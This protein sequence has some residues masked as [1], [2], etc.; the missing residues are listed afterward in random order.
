[1]YKI[2]CALFLTTFPIFADADNIDLIRYFDI[3]KDTNIPV[4]ILWVLSNRPCLT[5]KT[6]RLYYFQKARILK[7]I[8]EQY[9]DLRLFRRKSGKGD[10]V[11]GVHK[12]VVLNYHFSINEL[13]QWIPKTVDSIG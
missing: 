5:T 8:Y 7:K 10:I 6:E 2:L 1:M 12:G 11:N 9:Q 4:S 13:K 3:E